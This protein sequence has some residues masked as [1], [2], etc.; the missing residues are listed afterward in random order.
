MTM[1]TN[2]TCVD[3]EGFPVP[4]DA[5]GNNAAFRCVSCGG[6]VLAVLGPVGTQ[7][8]SAPNAC[9]CR[10]CGSKFWLEVREQEQRMVMR[11]AL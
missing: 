11:R 10:G 8:E 3:A 2:F 7:G 1:V 9:Q 6:P 5:K 4:C